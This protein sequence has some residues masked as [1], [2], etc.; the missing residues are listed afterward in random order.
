MVLL[1]DNY[2]SF[3][4]NLARYLEELGCET[5]VVRNDAIQVD[6]IRSLAP[7]AI[8]LS[9]G[10]CDP[11]QAGISLKIVRELGASIPMLGV[12]LGHQV[13]G[14]AHGGEVVRGMPVHGRTSKV[15]HDDLGIFRGLPNPF[16]AARYHSLV[17][18]P[19]SVPPDLEVSARTEDGT[20]MGIRHRSRTVVGIQ[21]HPES[22]LTEH[23]HRLLTNFIECISLTSSL[24]RPKLSGSK[25]A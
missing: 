14:A 21:F 23:G 24:A 12:C 11:R 6:E 18:S 10:P 4:Y 25:S 20:I 5:K 1:I 15:F 16:K 2:D 8:V 13:I 19:Q 9:P 22:V 17:I 3:V 7:E